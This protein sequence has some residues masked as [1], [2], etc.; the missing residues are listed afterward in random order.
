MSLARDLKLASL[1]LTVLVTTTAVY[2][3]GT[4]RPRTPAQS[5]EH[6]FHYIHANGQREHPDPRPTQLSEQEA[7]AYLASGKVRLPAGVQ[8]VRLVGTPGVIR[9]NCRIDFDAVRASSSNS[10]PLLRLFSGIHD[11]VVEAQ[12]SGSNYRGRVQVN[13]V[14]IDGVEVPRFLL[15]LFVEKYVTPRY[16]GVGLDSTF[17][18]PD[19][20]A[21][22]SV[23]T[24]TLVVL[25]R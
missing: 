2:S 24:H 5:A 23:L 7:N 4:E 22:A 14:S 12:A 11:V 17:T 20:I 8:S 16:P 19:R 9:A 6:K 15:E 3:P 10:N 21:T 18:L 25:Q 13:F 1:V